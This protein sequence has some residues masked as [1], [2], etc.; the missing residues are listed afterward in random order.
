MRNATIKF[1]GEEVEVKYQD[2]GYEPDTNAHGID[3]EFV[4]LVV[5]DFSADEETLVLDQLYAI[6]NDPHYHD[7]SDLL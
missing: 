5:P 2:Y 6:V 4:D 3:W 7:E 1:R